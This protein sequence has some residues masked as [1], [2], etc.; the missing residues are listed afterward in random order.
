MFGEGG[1]CAQKMRRDSSENEVPQSKALK[2]RDSGLSG[3]KEGPLLAGS[4]L[5]RSVQG[6]RGQSG[7]GKPEV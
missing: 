7:K 4:V 2:A 6:H 1:S 3:G 5:W